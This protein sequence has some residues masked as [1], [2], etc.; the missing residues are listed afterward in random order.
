MV[1]HMILSLRMLLCGI[2][3]WEEEEEGEFAWKNP[4]MAGEEHERWLVSADGVGAER[5]RLREACCE[6]CPTAAAGAC[7]GI[8]GAAAGQRFFAARTGSFDKGVSAE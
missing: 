7:R 6:P 2:G 8:A 3:R 4:T 1:F 5:C